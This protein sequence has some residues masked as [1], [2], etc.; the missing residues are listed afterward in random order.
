MKHESRGAN[1]K[2][3]AFCRFHG[4]LLCR[5][6]TISRQNASFFNNA[7]ECSAKKFYH[8]SNVMR[9]ELTN[10]VRI[11]TAIR[12]V[13]SFVLYLEERVKH[14]HDDDNSVNTY[15]RYSTLIVTCIVFRHGTFAAGQSLL[16]LLASINRV[17][18]N[19]GREKEK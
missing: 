18:K 2:S 8:S 1:R 5:I 9:F 10:S 4:F 6:L 19:Y 15:L 12:L 16:T 7:F 11:M 14:R 17:C 13:L 3:K